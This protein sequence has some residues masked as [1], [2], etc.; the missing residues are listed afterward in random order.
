MDRKPNKARNI[1]SLIGIIL[2][3]VLLVFICVRQTRSNMQLYEEYMEETS[4]ETE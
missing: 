4:A 1:L 3:L 2:L